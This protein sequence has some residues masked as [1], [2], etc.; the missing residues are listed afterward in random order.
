M[1]TRDPNPTSGGRPLRILHC[2]DFRL[3][4]P[5]LPLPG[6]PASL[7]DAYVESRYRAVERLFDRAIAERVDVV[8]IAGGTLDANLT[9]L[10]GPWHL[11]E[12]FGRLQ[13]ANIDVAWGSGQV[14]APHR[15]PSYVGLPAN[16]RRFSPTARTP[17][18]I[19]RDGCC[20]LVVGSLDAA[21]PA[22][23]RVAPF[24]RVTVVPNA[25][26]RVDDT[27]ADYVACGGRPN[28]HIGECGRIAWPGSPQGRS[29]DE[30]DSHGG[31]LVELHPDRRPVLLPI[32]SDV[33]RWATIA[34]PCGDGTLFDDLQPACL[35]ALA[36]VPVTADATFVSVRFDGSGLAVERL[37]TPSHQAAL[38]TQLRDAA[39][40]SLFVAELKLPREPQPSAEPD[41]LTEV[42]RTERD[43]LRHTSATPTAGR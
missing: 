5:C 17:V 29:F 16:V 32:E 34:I 6:L 28:R 25:P 36:D 10:R 31:L 9:G 39:A 14:D 22:H 7:Q 43:L 33:V 19:Q 40:D 3:D 35:A 37:R 11:V 21:T 13:A 26:P 42:A 20:P 23:L 27:E 30:S 41:V 15:W 18:V 8:V 24:V 4:T 12:Q 1:A 2:G 38:L